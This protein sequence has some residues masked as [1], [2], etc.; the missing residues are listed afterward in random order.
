M[1]C[2]LC[3]LK[4]KKVIHKETWEF[5]IIDC[6]SC[7]VPMIVWKAHTMEPGDEELEVMENA[8]RLV[9]KEIYRPWKFFIDKKQ[10]SVFDHIHWHARPNKHRWRKFYENTADSDIISEDA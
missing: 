5:I 2:S 10:N 8:L 4:D 3:E 9:G 1:S 6:S 7:E